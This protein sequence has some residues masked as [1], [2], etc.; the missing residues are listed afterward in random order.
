MESEKIQ[1]YRI[2]SVDVAEIYDYAKNKKAYSISCENPKSEKFGRLDFDKF[3]AVIYKSIETN[4][5][6]G[7]DLQ[8]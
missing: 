1:G 3:T 2:L 6:L 5:L 7:Y 4:K 8:I